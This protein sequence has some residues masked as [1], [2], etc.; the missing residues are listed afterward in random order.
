MTSCIQS[1]CIFWQKKNQN[2]I[3]AKLFLIR[4]LTIG[5]NKSITPSFSNFQTNPKIILGIFIKLCQIKIKLLKLFWQNPSS[6]LFSSSFPSL[7]SNSGYW[8]IPVKFTS[9]RPG[10]SPFPSPLSTSAQ[11]RP[12]SHLSPA[13]PR[14][15]CRLPQEHA[16]RVRSPWP[17]SSL[18]H[19]T[20]LP[21]PYI[22]PLPRGH[23]NPSSFP[24]SRR[25]LPP[26]S[27]LLFLPLPR[28]P[29]PRPK[30]QV[31]H[32]IEPPQSKKACP[33]AINNSTASC[34]P[35]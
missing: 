31:L 18:H 33:A 2:I 20:S 32:R 3:L 30:S 22:K 28:S 1:P 35:L 4:K 16:P 17:T 29:W 19:H 8:E 6:L 15:P 27:H 13:P 24:S 23:A 7:F 10:P 26:L 11:S 34:P 9:S 5:F 25:H 12:S 21:L 14:T